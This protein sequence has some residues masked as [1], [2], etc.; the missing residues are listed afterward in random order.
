LESI[1]FNAFHSGLQ[2]ACI[3]GAGVAVLGALAAFK[4]L[5][6]RGAPEVQVH[7]LS[8]P[9]GTSDPAP[10]SPLVAGTDRYPEYVPYVGV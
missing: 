2:V 10:A 6:G 7:A 3:A 9:Q 4:L 5:P 1:A 8:Q